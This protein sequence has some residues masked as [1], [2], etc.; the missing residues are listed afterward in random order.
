M[1]QAI[2]VINKEGFTIEF[3]SNKN[4]FFNPENNKNYLSQNICAVKSIRLYSEFSDIDGDSILYLLQTDDGQKGWI[5]DSYSI[6]A[7]TVLA[8]HINSIKKRLS[9]K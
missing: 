5:S 3:V 6:Y 4:G 7:D 2:E 1:L 9:Q 8:E